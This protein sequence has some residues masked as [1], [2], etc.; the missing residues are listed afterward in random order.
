[1]GTASRSLRAAIPLA[2]AIRCLAAGFLFAAACAPQSRPP[3]AVPPPVP[4][5]TAQPAVVGEGEAVDTAVLVPAQSEEQGVAWE[6][7]WIWRRYGRFRKKGV[8][9]ATL[10]G[11]RLDVVTVE[12]PDGSERTIYFDITEFFGR[13]K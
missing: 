10:A 9:L 2:G 5:R 8:G 4:T 12:L 11:R 13:G 3:A 7:D 1:M 6:N